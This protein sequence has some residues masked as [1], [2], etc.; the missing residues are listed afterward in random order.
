ML[1]IAPIKRALVPVDSQAAAAIADRNYDEFQGD[2]EIWSRLQQYPNSILR[3]TMSHCE[4]LTTDDMLVDGSTDALARSSKNMAE[5][6]GSPQTK[7]VHDALWIYE[8]VDPTRPGVR[9]IGL[10]CMAETQAIR[11]ADTPQGTI[12][13]NEG[14]REKKAAG[15]AKLIE[16][17]QS[18]IGVVNNTFEDPENEVASALEAIAD[19]RAPDFEVTDEKGYTHRSW[20]ETD[21]TTIE[22]LA[23]RM[24]GIPCAYVADGNHRSAAAAHL[25]RTHFLNVL[26]P[27]GRMGLAPYN[28]LVRTMGG[29]DFESLR[30][31]LADD[32]DVTHSHDVPD[33]Q[34]HCFGLYFG[35]SDG[36]LVLTPKPHTYDENN[37]VQVIDADIV[38]RHIF[39]RLLDIED[40]RDERLNFVGGDRPVPYLMSRVDNGEF[41]FA[42]SLAPVAMKSIIDICEQDRF[43][44]PKSTWFEPKIRIGLVVALFDEHP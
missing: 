8:I 14:I 42:V 30:T 34:H 28:R 10:G 5:L 11:T 12:I 17:T 15:R 26:F 36:W 7:V 27:S 19:R 24:R 41:A 20:I 9:Q 6:V 25:G 18:Y 2:H 4:A 13:R 35:T 43:M 40:A 39:H 1:T 32:F 22:E 44:P 21:R 29:H 16:A 37:A 38:Q 3:V 31:E 33:V 23:A